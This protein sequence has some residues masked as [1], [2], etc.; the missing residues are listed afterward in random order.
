MRFVTSL[1]NYSLIDV[2]RRV[3]TLE[4]TTCDWRR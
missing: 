2:H 3:V 4:F 1:T